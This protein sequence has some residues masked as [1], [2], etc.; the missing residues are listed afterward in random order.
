MASCRTLVL[1]IGTFLLLTVPA[2]AQGYISPYVGFNF[3]GDSGNCVSLQTCE[4]RRL[5]IGISL[6]TTHGIFGFEEDVAYARDFFGKT[7][8]VSNAVL[9]VMSNLMLVVPAG[10][11][12]PYAIIGLGLIRTHAEFDASNLSLDQ[13]AL[14]YDIGGGI[15]LFLAHSVGIRGDVRH[16]HTLQDVT[17]GLFSHDQL[18]FWRASAGLT[19]R[20]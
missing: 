12:Q 20:F 17:L 13:N 7:P 18:D 11:I 8:G 10:P 1:A 16:L 15:N 14:G 6:G 5:N 9:T 19:F 3:G 2:R 4:D